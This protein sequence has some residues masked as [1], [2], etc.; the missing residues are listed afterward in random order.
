MRDDPE[1]LGR[2]IAEQ[3]PQA[4]ADELAT[5]T[6]YVELVIE[7]STVLNLTGFRRA[8]EHLAAELVGEALRLHELATITSGTRA[9]DLGSGNGSPVVPLAILNPQARFTAVESR[10]RPAAFLRTV[11][12]RLGLANLTV[13]EQRAEQL[14]V[15]EHGAFALVTSRA[16]APL[17]KLVPLAFRLL[18]PGG[19]LRGYL[20]AD[21]NP[22]AARARS[23]GFTVT[24]CEQYKVVNARR[25]VYR[26]RKHA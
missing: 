6:A 10:S 25:H 4:V 21:A 22:L 9:V 7:Y 2:L 18:A 20:G 13:A 11:Q 15:A 8:P 24:A 16:F 23:S 5:M 14:A 19:E 12:A 17:D 1:K 26:L 3:M